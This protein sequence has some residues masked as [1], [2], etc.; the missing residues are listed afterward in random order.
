MLSIKKTLFKFNNLIDVTVMDLKISK[1]YG[2]NLFVKD[3]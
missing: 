2:T 3:N 1:L